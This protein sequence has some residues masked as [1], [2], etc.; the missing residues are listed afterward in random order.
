[1]QH[2]TFGSW[3]R[4]GRS[5][6]PVATST[7]TVLALLLLLLF[8]RCPSA[9]ADNSSAK[10]PAVAHP[11]SLP[12][13]TALMEVLAGGAD[14]QL[15]T[16]APLPAHPVL[17][18]FTD[19]VAHEEANVDSALAANA[20]RGHMRQLAADVPPS[21]LRVHEF[22]IP[23]TVVDRRFVELLLIGTSR[24]PALVLFHGDASKVQVAPGA[25][26]AASP[27]QAA[28]HY[29]AASPAALAHLSYVELR[30][31]ALSELPGRYTDPVTLHLIPSL[32][33]VFSTA[34]ILQTVRLVRD[35]VAMT[36]ATA[37]ANTSRAT[38]PSLVS[39]AYVRLTRHGSE[40]V[41]AALSSLAT[42]AGNG[43]LVLVTESP[44]VAAAFGLSHEHTLTTAPWSSVLA[45]CE[46]AAGASA[47]ET[48]A[49]VVAGTAAPQAI[50]T[51]TEVA[52]VASTAWGAAVTAV[53]GAEAVQLQAW[54]RAMDA[55]TTTSPLRKVDTA[56]QLLHELTV[57]QNAIKVV[58]VLR[59]SDE[60]WFH[61]HLDVAVAV[62]RRLQQTTIRYNTTTLEKGAKVRRRVEKAW[63]PPMRLEVFWVDAEQ[64]PAAAD[65]LYV[66]QVPSVLVL[67]P[68]QSRFDDGGDGGVDAAAGDAAAARRGDGLRRR[69]PFIGVHVVS[70]YDLLTAA[71]TNDPLAG[72]EAVTGKEALPLFPSD[73]DAL[74]RFLASDS[75]D[76]AMQN[77]MRPLR[78]SALRA[79]L[80]AASEAER[81][82]GGSSSGSTSSTTATSPETSGLPNRVY[83]RLD[84]RYYPL[85]RAE[86][87]VEGPAYVR[88]ILNGSAPLPVLADGE[89]E[90]GRTQANAGGANTGA[91]AGGGGAPPITEAEAAAQREKKAA[92]EAELARRRAEKEARMRRKAAED[93]AARERQQAAFQREVNAAME[94]E[95]REAQ[96][97]GAAAG[98]GGA[99]GGP[100]GPRRGGDG[101]LVRRP[102]LDAADSPRRGT[103]GARGSRGDAGGAAREEE[104]AED[105]ALR[106]RRKQRHQ[107]YREWLQDR[108]RMVNRSVMVTGQGETTMLTAWE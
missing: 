6:G 10:P 5:P 27:F 43:V 12:S 25:V 93:A 59:E 23:T 101:F 3:T 38:A 41:V 77:A 91:A 22:I 80:E 85:W 98:G 4:R 89:D 72:Q 62:A 37:S 67:A 15:P 104:D 68:L 58:F 86:E 92:W 66:S 47:A 26:I 36:P 71:F 95:E 51:V 61:H 2:S 45:A 19:S 16:L 14:G 96:R 53:A 88:Q 52:E 49:V 46:H 60:M 97:A 29:T 7:S 1:M 28:T 99:P 32:Q 103:S 54:R 70:R 24:V 79:Q 56:P 84:R 83:L 75:F 17:I 13:A 106:L 57:L 44:E 102:R 78:L 30:Q 107:E 42:Q 73:C 90:R 33:F 39:L 64:L 31:W 50:G 18:L 9:L 11:F 48:G 74:T 81:A 21:V 100:S 94:T 63:S 40:E 65:G 69:D 105:A 35:A 55:F 108:Q 8:L 82:T 76:G 87:P 34:D 20:L